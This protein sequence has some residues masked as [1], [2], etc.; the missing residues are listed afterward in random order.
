MNAQR[1]LIADSDVELVE[2]LADYFRARG[3]EVKTAYDAHTILKLVHLEAPEAFV[4]G[5]DLK[6]RNGICVCELLSDERRFFY[7]PAILLTEQS[8]DWLKHD[9]HDLRAAYVL[10]G[11]RLGERIND[12]LS[13][14]APAAP[15]F[16]AT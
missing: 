4:L 12:L 10:K 15:V 2:G 8:D 13:E 11:D 7:I 16:A 14:L 5:I 9:C 6:C 3:Y 1:I